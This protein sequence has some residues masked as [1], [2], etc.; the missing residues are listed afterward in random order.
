M[1]TMYSCSV[2]NLD[3]YLTKFNSHTMNKLFVYIE[4]MKGAECSNGRM[5]SIQQFD[6]FKSK[7]TEPYYKIENKHVDPFIM[8]NIV[9]HLI[10]II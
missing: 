3:E 7:I 8:Q 9:E 10:I 4:E 1:E 5:K 6:N 2:N